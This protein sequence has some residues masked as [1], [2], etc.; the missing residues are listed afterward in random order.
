MNRFNPNGAQNRSNKHHRQVGIETVEASE[1][2]LETKKID[3]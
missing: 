2:C 1:G 3:Y